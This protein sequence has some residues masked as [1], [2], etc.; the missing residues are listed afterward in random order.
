MRVEVLP[1]GET[2]LP[3]GEPLA[4]NHLSVLKKSAGIP[5]MVVFRPVG[6]ALT[7][8]SRYRVTVDGLTQKGKPRRLR[9]FVNFFDFAYVAPRVDQRL[10]ATLLS[11]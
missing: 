5:Y 10:P 11:R 2:F 7:A 8:G 6:V 4:L 9:Y 1:V 3:A